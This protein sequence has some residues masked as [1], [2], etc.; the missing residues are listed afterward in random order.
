MYWKIIVPIVTAMIGAFGGFYAS[1]GLARP[2]PFHDFM[3]A[4]GILFVID[5][6]AGE[7]S[8][9]LPQSLGEVVCG[10][11]TEIQ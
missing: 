4:D 5:R 9:C 7:V 6:A 8:V 10:T 3:A 1:A 2:M 11:P